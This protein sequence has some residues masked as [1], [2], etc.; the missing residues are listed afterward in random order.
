MTAIRLSW[1]RCLIILAVLLAN[2][3]GCGVPTA[4]VSGTITDAQGPAPGSH[5]VFEVDGDPTQ[6]YYG[7]SFGEGAYQVDDRGIMPPAKYTI[8]V[9]KYETKDGKSLPQSE[10]GEA[11]KENGTAVKRRFVLHKELVEGENALNLNLAEAQESAIAEEE[12][13]E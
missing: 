12:E 10:E 6:K 7:G 1:T 2:A 3:V 5:V 4:T 13:E 9:T 8:T 11:M